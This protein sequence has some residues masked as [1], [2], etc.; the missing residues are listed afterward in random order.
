MKPRRPSAH[1]TRHIRT[2]MPY[3]VGRRRRYGDDPDIDTIL[4]RAIDLHDRLSAEDTD[5]HGWS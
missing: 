3:S 5:N 4:D 1:T 2:G